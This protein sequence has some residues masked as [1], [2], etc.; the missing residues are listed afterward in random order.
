MVFWF[1]V[2][3]SKYWIPATVCCH[4][5]LFL[6]AE[7]WR[8]SQWMYGCHD[9]CRLIRW[10]SQCLYVVLFD[11]LPR[12]G[13]YLH[14][15]IVLKKTF[16]PARERER[17]PLFPLHRY[18]TESCAETVVHIHGHLSRAALYSQHISSAHTGNERNFKNK[19]HYIPNECTLK[20]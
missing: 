19:L 3:F 1:H 13:L 2:Y 18:P 11:W 14:A 15:Q 6:S 9:I 20:I 10:K 17:D 8:K 16:L 12:N 4:A 5:V 7:I